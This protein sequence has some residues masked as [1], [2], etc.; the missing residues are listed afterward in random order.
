MTTKQDTS[1]TTIAAIYAPGKALF[2]N[3]LL[4]LTDKAWEASVNL[5]GAE[6]RKAWPSATGKGVW[7][8]GVCEDKH[9]AENGTIDN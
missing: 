4:D 8:S 3:D 1:K 6:I 7:I 2:G 5:T 9:Y